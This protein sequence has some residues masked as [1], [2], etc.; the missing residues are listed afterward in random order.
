MRKCS[1]SLGYL[2]WPPYT[3][4]MNDKDDSGLEGE[5]IFLMADKF[6]LKLNLTKYLYEEGNMLHLIAS[7][8]ETIF[9]LRNRK[10]RV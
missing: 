6:N 7:Q 9:L 3:I 10:L 2:A 4:D 1:F 5:L 8:N